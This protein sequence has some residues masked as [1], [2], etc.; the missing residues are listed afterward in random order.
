MKNWK[1]RKS[2][3]RL[4][5]ITLVVLLGIAI[6]S[7]G[8]KKEAGGAETTLLPLLSSSGSQNTSPPPPET[9]ILPPSS[10]PLIPALTQTT[11]LNNAANIPIN[12]KLTVV[13]SK[14]VNIN[15]VTTNTA[16]NN[17]SGSVSLS[18]DNFVTCVRMN[19]APTSPFG[20]N[21]ASFRL[22]PANNLATSTPYKIRVLDTIVDESGRKLSATV[23]TS[24]GTSASADITAPGIQHSLPYDGDALV[25]TNTSIS[26]T[27]TEAMEA[28]SLNVNTTNTTCSGSIQ[29]SNNNFVSCKRIAVQP[30]FFNQMRSVAIKPAIPL[31]NFEDYEIKITAGAKDVAGNS[32][33][34]QILFFVTQ[35]NDSTAPQLAQIFP[36]DNQIGVARNRVFTLGFTEKMNPTSFV[37]NPINNTCSGTVQISADNFNTCVRLNANFRYEGDNIGLVHSFFLI[38]PLEPQT[39]YKIRLANG[40]QDLSGNA[41][42]GGTQATGFTTGNDL[43][44]A[45]PTILGITP[46]DGSVNQPYTGYNVEIRFSKEMNPNDFSRN[47]SN[48]ACR[49]NIQLSMDNFVN[50][51]RLNALTVYTGNNRIRVNS[52]GGSLLPNTTYK[53][54]IKGTIR[55]ASDNAL[56][57]DF[58]QTTG[59]TTEP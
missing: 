49:G 54:R 52:G 31:E 46:N 20:T 17:C 10:S 50:C 2:S 36:N 56:G 45:P 42:A 8:D 29:I 22:D 35:T 48:G 12:A 9:G 53:V 4:F 1:K 34:E 55:D 3:L 51:I 32:L 27:F 24:F 21:S 15:S 13:F 5:N 58:T 19:S 43:D 7:C 47:I 38:D 39:V 16:D 40:I 44:N 6:L 59:F 41:F 30:Q 18:S 57:A 37:L 28:T 33:N 14:V 11:P 25:G 23:T 26:V